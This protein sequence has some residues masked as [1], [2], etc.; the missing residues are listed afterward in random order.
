MD[1]LAPTLVDSDWVLGDAT[2]LP[3]IVIH[4]LTGPIKVNGQTWSLEMPPL[5]AALTD[6]QVAGVLTYIRR[7]WEHTASPISLAQVQKIRAEHKDRTKAWTAEELGI[8]AKKQA[9]K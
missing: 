9:K 1:G 4:G 8:G 2:V 6:E 7:E 3:R 5:G